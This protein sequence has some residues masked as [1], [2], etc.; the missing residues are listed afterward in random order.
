MIEHIRQLRTIQGSA[1]LTL[2]VLSFLPYLVRGKLIGQVMAIPLA[3]LVLTFIALQIVAV[4]RERSWRMLSA[5]YYPHI[6]AFVSIFG[7]MAL[8]A[9][10]I[11][12]YV[13]LPAATGVCLGVLG[14]FTLRLANSSS[15]EDE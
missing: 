7:V 4:I 5:V 13:L 8:C 15:I 6:A 2:A 1:F 12:P 9:L 10:N 3:G 14:G 11:L